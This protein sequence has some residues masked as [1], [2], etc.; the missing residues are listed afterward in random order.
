MKKARDYERL[1]GAGLPIPDYDVFDERCLHDADESARLSVLVTRI[2]NRGSGQVGVRTE[3]KERP[4]SLGNYPHI[5]PLPTEA[6]V[7]RAIEEVLDHYPQESWWFLVNEAFTEYEWNA[8]VMV[9]N[10]LPLP[11]GPRLVGEVNDQDNVPLREALAI[12]A[13]TRTLSNWQHADRQWLRSVILRS[14]LL[15]EWME[16]SSVHARGGLRKVFWGMR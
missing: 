12:S 8:V 10:R 16:V 4:S 2:L 9:T 5:M 1:R 6:S 7:R 13:N 15:D 3:P 14:G 11:G